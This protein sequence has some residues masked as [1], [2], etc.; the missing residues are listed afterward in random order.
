MSATLAWRL[1]RLRAMDFAEVR[2]RLR[3]VLA[4]GLERRGVG[5]AREADAG[6]RAAASR[7]VAEPPAELRAG[8]YVDAAERILAGRWDVLAL[9]DRALGFPPRWNRDPKT[10]I[11][12]PLDFGKALDYRDARLVGDAKYLWEPN[13]HHELVTL[14]QAWRLT[15]GPRFAL[16]AQRLVDSW[17]EQCPYP[18]GPQWTSALEVAVRLANW[19]CAWHLFGGEASPLFAPAAGRAFRRRWLGAVYRHCHFVWRNLSRHSSA[20]NHLF[21]ELTGLFIAAL[22]WPLWRESALWRERSR[23]G[24]EAEALA[25]VGED[26]VDREQA[27]WYQH[28]VAD[29]MLLALLFARAN[30]VDFSAGFSS[31]LERMLEFIAAVTDAAGHVPAIGDADDGALLRLARDPGFCP[32]GSLLATGAVLYGRGD[33]KA[34]AARFDDKSR[35]LLG[36]SA[37]RRFDALPY[38]GAQRLRRAF[39]EGGYYVLGRDFGTPREV[40]LVADAGPLGYLSIAAHGHADALAFTLSAGGRELLVDPGTYAYHCDAR[41][42]AYFRGTAAHNTLRVDGRDQSVPGGNFLWRAHARAACERFE[43]AGE[44]EVFEATH[45]GYLRLRDPVRHRRRIELDG[46]ALRI[47]VIDALQCAAPHWVEIHWHLAPECV[48]SAC[49]HA[50]EV[51]CANVRLRVECP[52]ELEA[53]KVIAGQ[54]DP[55]LGWVSRGLDEKTPSPTIVCAGRVAGGRSLVSVL[56]LAIDPAPARMDH[57]CPVRLEERA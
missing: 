12:A 38:A 26:G 2:W 3:R 8:P 33:F 34:R 14:A 47:E 30:G 11:E 45:D 57:S 6:E 13:R 29:M 23:A 10:G 37:A 52:C 17:L 44:R 49:G 55:P 1:N 15:G 54:N 31:R 5:L 43:V 51:A 32:F 27:L 35:W 20:N 39:P 16:G 56:T 50:V 7:W 4:A 24:L 40:K 22:T 21:G 19:A 41:W 36:D 46:R 25:Q 53:P 18:R 48:A 9:R 42:R 28:E